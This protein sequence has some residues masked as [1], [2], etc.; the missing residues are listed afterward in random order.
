M[1]MIH[2]HDDITKTLL[3]VIMIM[4][5]AKDNDNDS[6]HNTDENNANYFDKHDNQK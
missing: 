3:I 6:I 4:I 5:V 2:Y 1:I